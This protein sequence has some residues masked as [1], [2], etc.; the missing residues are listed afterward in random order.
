MASERHAPA[1]KTCEIISDYSVAEVR[2]MKYLEANA[3]LC[4]I[5]ESLMEQLKSAHEKTA[6]MLRRVCKKANRREV[7]GQINDFGDPAFVPRGF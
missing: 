1:E 5:Q 7:P 4:G 2:M 6:V 3:A